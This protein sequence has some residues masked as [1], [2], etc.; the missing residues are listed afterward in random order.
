MWITLLFMKKTVYGSPLRTALI[1]SHKGGEEKIPRLNFIL[2][3]LEY[4]PVRALVFQIF[5]LCDKALIL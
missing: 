3:I 1:F 5:V 2:K 4:L